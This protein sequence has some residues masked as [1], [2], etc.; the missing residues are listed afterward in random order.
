LEGSNL[1]RALIYRHGDVGLHKADAC[2]KNCD[3]LDPAGVHH[4][5]WKDVQT[6]ADLAEYSNARA[7]VAAVDGD[8]TREVSS[9]AFRSMGIAFATGATDPFGAYVIYQPPGSA[10]F[11]CQSGV[12]SEPQ[13]LPSGPSCLQTAEPSISATNMICA[14]LLSRG[15]RAMLAGRRPVNLRFRGERDTG[16]RLARKATPMSDCPH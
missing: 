16:N 3:E 2:P 8:N 12:T 10:C 6:N 4:G 1:N 9:R 13:P 5:D 11:A 14:A 15:L 7:A